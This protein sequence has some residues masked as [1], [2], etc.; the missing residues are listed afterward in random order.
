MLTTGVS[1]P[2]KFF[3]EYVER[4]SSSTLSIDLHAGGAC[5]KAFE[6]YRHA[7]YVDGRS[8][9]DARCLAISA[10][11]DFWG[12]FQTDEDEV[13]SFERVLTSWLEYF[14]A[15]PPED[16]PIR[17]LVTADGAAI[18]FTF[19]IPIPVPHPETGDPILYGG[20]FDM[21]GTMGACLY[22]VDEKTSKR[23][24]PN[25]SK[26]WQM[27]AQFLGYIWAAR[28]YGFAVDGYVARGI[29]IHKNDSVHVQSIAGVP[30]WRIEHW[31]KQMVRNVQRLVDC[32]KEGY[33]DFAYGEAC[34]AYFKPCIFMPL[35]TSDT[36]ENWYGDYVER[37]WDPLKKN[38]TEKETET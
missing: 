25:W 34:F 22:V 32:Y 9:D 28:E 18:E 24:D 3:R 6:V 26:L 8:F 15:Y 17:P 37:T 35:C 20:R 23:I 38:P 21:L 4:R 30:Q 1:C 7:Y 29:I 5:A 33:F 13:K 12:D 14:D 11:I 36:P 19:A 10:F 16:D 27:R 2:Q 31:Y